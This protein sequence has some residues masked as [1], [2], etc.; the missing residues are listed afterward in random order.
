[1]NRTRILILALIIPLVLMPVMVHAGD[2]E[3]GL[4]RNETGAF[5]GYTLISPLFST[6]SFLVD[7][8]G[9]VVHRWQREFPPGQSIYLL[10]D[11]HLL[12]TANPGPEN[13]TV[14]HGGGAGG[15]IQ[16][17][18][19]EGKLVWDFEFSGDRHLQH[20]DIE[21]M[22][23]GNVLILAWELK[24]EEEALSAGRDPE[25][26]SEQGLWPD[27]VVEVKPE[28]KTGGTIVWEWHAWD[29]LVQEHDPS[30]ANY[31]KVVQNPRRID[32]NPGSWESGLSKNE[33]EKLEALGYLQP[34][35]PGRGGH[36]KGHGASPD[37]MH[38]NS[39]DYNAELDQVL[40]SVL[41][42]NEIWVI[43][44]DTTTEEAAGPAG[45]LLYRW[46]NP[47]MHGAGTA[48]DRQLF[49]QH[50][51]R[52]VPGDDGGPDQILI[53][54]NGRG[55]PGGDWSTVVAIVPPLSGDG[56]Y[57]WPE[58]GVPGPAEPVWAYSSPEKGDFYSNFISGA[59]RLGNGNTLICS[60][61]EGR[62][63]EV[64]PAGET[65]WEYRNPVEGNPMSMMAGRVGR[66][67]PPGGMMPP[68]GGGFPGGPPPGMISPGRTM[69]PP[70]MI[71][72]P[73]RD[74]YH[75]GHISSLML[76][77]VRVLPPPMMKGGGPGGPQRG[78]LLFRASRFGPEY[79]AFAGRDLTPRKTIEAMIAAE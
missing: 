9:R 18:D 47:A 8:E 67:G 1:M 7:L 13:P 53:F 31:G 69:P 70:E 39:V 17:Y 24:T 29:H 46:G 6:E 25:M 58:G 59:E 23:D 41:G 50:D 34:E 79:P 22:P 11:G 3:T 10:D 38:G 42:Y 74:L 76:N 45:D 21:M 72:E 48:E 63:F 30:K 77:L 26:L 28:G 19:W 51:A 52:W 73:I 54:N 40:V 35:A 5:P 33:R 71:P 4:V 78:N 43:D 64:T 75:G 32:L 66:D 44:H 49:A 36:D 15:R 14:F 61:A 27:M 57:S 20:H 60:G 2:K 65:V 37:F 16:E 56:S 12:A 55:R 62:V 68:G